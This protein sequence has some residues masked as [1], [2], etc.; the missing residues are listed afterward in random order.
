M[1]KSFY[2]ILG[3]SADASDAELKKAYRQLS[4][5]YHPDRCSDPDAAHIMQQVNEAYETLSDPASRQQYDFSLSHPQGHPP[6]MDMFFQQMFGGFPFAQM[7]AG[8][9]GGTGGINIEIVHGPGGAT[10][11]RQRQNPTV[12]QISITLEQAFTG[13]T[14]PVSKPG[15][16]EVEIVVVPAGINNGQTI[17]V[18]QDFHVCINISPHH[19]FQRSGND[20]Y[21][22]K[23]LT[24]KE[25]LCGA[26][27]SFMH[28]NGKN[29]SLN[30]SNTVVSPGAKKAFQ[31]MGFTQDGSLI[32]EFDVAFPTALSQEQRDTLMAVL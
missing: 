14:L 2:E 7:F 11:I 10:F 20:L 5:K 30:I 21:T 25:A 16:S 29:L 28:L 32:V 3:V 24:L 19:L 23:T 1:S 22:K 6:N 12:V 26:Q 17:A 13:A 31:G 8:G 18:S 4:L 9:G 15:S 27:F